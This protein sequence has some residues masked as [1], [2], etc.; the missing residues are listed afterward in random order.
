M[1][2]QIRTE[3]TPNPNAIKFLSD[4]R[5]I[6]DGTRSYRSAEECDKEL[7]KALFAIPHVTELYFFDNIITVTQ[8]GGTDWQALGEEISAGLATHLPNHNPDE[9]AGAE[10][11]PVDQSIAMRQISAIL[12]VTIR[13]S[14]QSDG[15][16]LDIIEYDG[17]LLKVM[18]KGACGSCPSA[19]AGTL[20]AI[21]GILRDKFSPEIV[22]QQ[23]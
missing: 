17:T 13:P 18:Y 12:D 10:E 7:P 16:D 11:A 20:Q 8:D 23:V 9:V 2:V 15:G 21:Q 19:A 6:T 14:L 5:V 22:V 4:A 1:Q 3:T